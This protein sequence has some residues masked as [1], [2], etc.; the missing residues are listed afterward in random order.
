MSI[1]KSDGCYICGSPYTELHHIYYGKNRENSD[2][3]GFTCKLCTGHHRGTYG[4]HGKY[5]A[6][7]DRM[8]KERCQEA[9]EQSHTRQEFMKIIGKN[10]RKESHD[11]DNADTF[12]S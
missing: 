10:Y 11:S 6:E 12:I 3:H 5:G 8:L 4:V 2:R 7:L 1:L 9:F